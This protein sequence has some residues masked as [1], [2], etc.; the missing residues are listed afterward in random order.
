[1][2]LLPSRTDSS[3]PVQASAPIPA[4]IPAPAPVSMT[5]PAPTTAPVE[6]KPQGEA[7]Q[8]S[9]IPAQRSLKKRLKKQQEN[10]EL[11]KLG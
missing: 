1:M 8:N 4:S 2:L 9:E 7:V 11:R 5:A 6:S 10:Q 3:G